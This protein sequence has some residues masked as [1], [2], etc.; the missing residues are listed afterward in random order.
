MKIESLSHNGI[1]FP[2]EY[3]S[4]N[5][6]LENDKLK[7]LAEEML[8]CYSIRNF[9]SLNSDQLKLLNENFYSC[10]KNELTKS[11][12]KIKFPNDFKTILDELAHFKKELTKEEKEIKRA[13]M[14]KIK[15]K[16]GFAIVNGKKE[17]LGNYFVE[18]PSIFVGRGDCP[19]LGFWKY[20]VYP[21]DVTINVIN[22]EPPK[23]PKGHK[24]KDITNKDVTYIAFYNI[25]V[26]NDIYI[27]KEVRFAATSSII[28]D[29]D[30]HKFEKSKKLLENWDDVQ[31]KIR[32]AL[33]SEDQ[34]IKECA[35]ISWL[36]QYTSIRIGSEETD[37][38]VVGASTLKCK[39]IKIKNDTTLNLNFIG[40]DSINY[41]QDFE[42]P[43]YIISALK[44]CLKGKN[45]NDDLFEVTYTDVNKFLNDIL[46][47]LTAKVF[48]TAWAEKLL[49]ENYKPNDIKKSWPTDYKVLLLK[50][51]LTKVSLMLNHK[52]T[53]TKILDD[54]LNK[55]KEQIE[56][57]NTK[58]ESIKDEKKKEKQKWKIKTLELKYE[59]V[60]LSFGFNLSTALTNYI[61]PEIVKNICKDKDIPLDKIYSKALIE[62]FK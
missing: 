14:D 48:R 16:Y 10:L 7:P 39:N 2:K 3:E 56:K 57:A 46:E 19:Y 44:K 24:W 41:N 21:E 1:V 13:E 38:G 37:N 25:K 20:R 59:F 4:H 23:P 31:H 55:I 30:S 18:P 33:D 62:R 35:L 6:I 32:E 61:N 17:A 9:N 29:S 15:K 28:S 47:G 54:S 53:T 34:K 43:K 49:I 12:Q 27:R 58:I 26:G 42:V 22:S 8:Y 50:I 60:K 45:E 51:L 5:L 36:I 52:K 11:Q 40:K